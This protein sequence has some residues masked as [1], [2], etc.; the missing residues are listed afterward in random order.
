[1]IVA[2]EHCKRQMQ[3]EQSERA[4]KYRVREHHGKEHKERPDGGWP[5]SLVR[6][7]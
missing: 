6:P 4:V 3:R 5:E 2:G 1:M 7:P